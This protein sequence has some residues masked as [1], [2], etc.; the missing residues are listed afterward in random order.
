MRNSKLIMN[1]FLLLILFMLASN[2][3][4]LLDGRKLRGGGRRRRRRNSSDIDP[5]FHVG[6]AV[7]DPFT[8]DPDFLDLWY[9]VARSPH[10]R[11]PDVA[12]TDLTLNLN[13]DIDGNVTAVKSKTFDG[14]EHTKEGTVH[15]TNGDVGKLRFSFESC[16]SSEEEAPSPERRLASGESDLPNE[17]VLE[18]DYTS[19]AI[20]Y[21]VDPFDVSRK[22]AVLLARDYEIPDPDVA[23]HLVTIESELGIAALDMILVEHTD[24]PGPLA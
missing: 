22:R 13:S 7:V 12:P 15:L 1:K 5:D 19:Y 14:E 9:V 23:A 8:L 16:E 20:V 17:F 4:S 18:T 10:H 24:V 3:I 11:E 2:T 6:L 21:S